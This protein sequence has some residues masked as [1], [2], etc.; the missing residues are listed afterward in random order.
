MASELVDSLQSIWLFLL[1]VP[2]MY[3]CLPQLYD[4]VRASV[5]SGAA[6]LA[7]D[8]FE[9]MRDTALLA[10]AAGVL[11]QKPRLGVHRKLMSAFVRTFLF[12]LVEAGVSRR[13][14]CF[15]AFLV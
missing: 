11:R 7:P 1:A 2:S 13:C 15:R 9:E 6:T 4:T 8:A 14:R 3:A 10:L 5:E 12:T